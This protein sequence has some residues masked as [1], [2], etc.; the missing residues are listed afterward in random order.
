MKKIAF[1]VAAASLFAFA[2][3]ANRFGPVA[4]SLALVWLGVVLAIAASGTIQS[5]AIG[6]GAL[7]AFGSGVLASVSPAAAGAVLVAA[8]FA[9]RTTR[10]RSRTARAVHVVTALVGG[11][12]AGALS[13]SF[14]SASLP[15]LAVA[16]VV[17]AVLAALPLLVE[18]DDPVAHA[19]DEAASL[20]S[21]PA[22]RELER[23]AELRRNAEDVPLDRA[24]AARV[25]TTWQSLLR[26]AEARVRLERSRPQALLR[27]AAQITAP[28]VRVV[29]PASA[30]APTDATEA[31]P[32]AAAPPASDSPAV[33]AA[34]PSAADAVLGMVDQR[35][36]EHVAVLA[37][38]YTA[39]D[40]VSAARIGLDDS[41]LKNV[42]S[43]GE[44]L[45]EVSRAIV[46]VRAEERLPSAAS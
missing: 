24:T 34:P 21:E 27:I 6:G 32:P 15:V 19:L 29:A 20:V 39:V 44:S 11:G 4:G 26:L 33:A 5:L 43:M 40:A 38:A 22:R 3:L 41:A 16:A 30:D 1:V 2:P 45:E 46:E 28:A 31:A 12:F 13:S 36:G 14:T 8:A 7:G 17:A 37:R 25:R 18:A 35:I 9:E 42:E 23:G 10:V